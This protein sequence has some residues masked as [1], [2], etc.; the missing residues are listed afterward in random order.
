MTDNLLINLNIISKISPDDKIYINTE[1][2]IS[3]ENNNILQGIV[4]FIFNNSRSKSINNL[5]NFYSLV[6]RYVDELLQTKNNKCETLVH[7]NDCKHHNS[8]ALKNLNNYIEKSLIG[9]KNLK[10]TYSN[11]VVITSK[12]DIIIDNIILYNEKTSN[13]I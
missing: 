2:Y 3:I 13:Y 6:F 7:L 12:L 10:K 5:S 9:I 1:G 11:D 4:R 8:L